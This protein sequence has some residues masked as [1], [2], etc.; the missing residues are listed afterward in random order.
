MVS[1]RVHKELKK[2][3]AELLVE[4]NIEVRSLGAVIEYIV[5]YY[6]KA[7]QKEKE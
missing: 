4:N 2:L 7:K 1:D 3:K 6:K 5:D